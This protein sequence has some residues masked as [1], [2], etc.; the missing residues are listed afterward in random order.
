MTKNV[1]RE[2]VEFIL[3]HLPEHPKDIVRVTAE[4]IGVAVPTVHRHLNRLIKNGDVVK[5][6]RTRGASYF[7][8]NARNKNVVLKIRPGMEEHTIWQDYFADS[9]AGL[10]RNVLSICDYG[11][12]EMVNNVIDHSEGNSLRIMTQWENN[13]VKIIVADNGIGVFRKIKDVFHLEDEQESILQLSKGKLTTDEDNHSGQGIFFTSRAFDVFLLSSFG[14]AYF[15]DNKEEDWYV[16]SDPEE[17]R[18]TA[19]TLIIAL[20]S[21]RDIVKV[22]SDY[23][24]EEPEE[25]IPRFDKTH[26]P[27]KLSQ[28]GEE[29]MVSRSQ[30]RRVLL[31]LE[32]F[33]HVILDFSG[34]ETVGQGFV[35]EV[36]RVYHNKR[37]DIT[38]EYENA[39]R[40]VTFMI[41]RS[42]PHD[43]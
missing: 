9:F 5:T 1:S 25:G 37:P 21:K 18:G 15:R 34:I 19:V 3:K 8:K 41:E 43:K 22:F 31:G 2:I 11:F 23:T 35:D 28:G 38:I 24:T 36:F 13:S 39:N 16:K 20:D 27:V 6:G 26:V 32:K 29:R 17:T 40:D 4:K 7:L 12:M 42:I 33:R 30:A 10:P 14:L